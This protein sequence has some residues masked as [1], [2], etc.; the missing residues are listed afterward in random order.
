MQQRPQ[1]FSTFIYRFLAV[2]IGHERIQ[3]PARVFT[4]ASQGPHFGLEKACPCVGDRI[5]HLWL[6]L[7]YIYIYIYYVLSIRIYRLTALIASNYDWFAN[8][9]EAH[10]AASVAGAGLPKECWLLPAHAHP[11]G[12]LAPGPVWIGSGVPGWNRQWEDLGVSPAWD[13]AHE[14][15]ASGGS[16]RWPHCTR[17]GAH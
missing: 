6:I 4:F 13:D 11:I 3:Y 10:Q 17:A 16:W 8:L 7:S 14:V 1:S 2:S 15:S 9:G 12:R 5:R